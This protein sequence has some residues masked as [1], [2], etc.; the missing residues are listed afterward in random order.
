M[1]ALNWFEI[2]VANFDR[3]VKFYSTILNAKMAVK[4]MGPS[5]MAHFPSSRPGVGGAVVSDPD[6]KPGPSGARVFLNAGDNLDDVLNRVETAGGKVLVHKT[7]ITA[8]TGYWALFR[9]TEGNHVGLLS[10]K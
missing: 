9:D 7:N 1:N 2:P 10:P 8:E 5:A 4:G 6:Q 3:A